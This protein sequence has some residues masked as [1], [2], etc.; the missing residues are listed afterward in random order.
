MSFE[1]ISIGDFC[2]TINIG[3]LQS[4]EY[5]PV[6]WI[7]VFP[8]FVDDNFEITDAITLL[9]GKS[10]LTA[11]VLKNSLVF[12]EDQDNAKQG[13][14]YVQE[15]KAIIPLWN[16]NLSQIY[17]QMKNH[18]F[19]VIVLD[20][21]GDKKI[22]GDMLYPLQFSANLNTGATTTNLKSTDISF[23]S[24]RPDKAYGYNV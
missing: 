20:K 22:I 9:P 5:I 15:L 17:N 1:L 2:G 16:N 12:T 4:I 11:K 8:D 6:S 24:Q 23:I 10:I 13:K 21:S 19:I 18:R 3:G 7:D 14:S